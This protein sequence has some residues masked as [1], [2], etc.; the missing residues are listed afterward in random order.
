MFS[1]KVCGDLCRNVKINV[2]ICK[3]AFIGCNFSFN[4]ALLSNSLSLL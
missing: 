3:N 1:F 4:S 2:Y